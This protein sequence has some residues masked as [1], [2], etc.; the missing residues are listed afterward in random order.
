MPHNS[1]WK[2]L[3][4]NTIGKTYHPTFNL[5]S[6]EQEP[7]HFSFLFKAWIKSR[8]RNLGLPHQAIVDKSSALQKNHIGEKEKENKE[9]KKKSV[10]GSQP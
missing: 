6:V 7:S 5:S 2:I 1:D 3:L 4:P 9:D 8:V 10:R